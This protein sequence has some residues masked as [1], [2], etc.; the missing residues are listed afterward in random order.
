MVKIVALLTRRQDIARDRFLHAWQVE[1]PPLV[2]RLPGLR[3]YVQ[4]PAVEHRRSW[5]YDGAAELWFDDVAAVAAAFATPAGDA[6]RE[7][8]QTFIGTLDWFLTEELE[9]PVAPDEAAG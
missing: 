4:S 6:L 5:T 9:I 7:H 2:R 3:R 8:E 1:H